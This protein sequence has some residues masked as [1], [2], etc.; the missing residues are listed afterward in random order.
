LHDIGKISVP[1]RILR[2]PGKLTEEEW[3]TMREHPDTG[4]RMLKTIR[5]PDAIATIVRQH[6]ERFD[7]TGY[8]HRLAGGA[9]SLGAR[10]FAVA[11]YYDAL[12]SNRPYRKA[13]PIERVL[14]DIRTASGSHFDPAVAETFLA[15][16]DGVFGDL[17]TR[18]EQELSDRRAA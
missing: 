9:I 5:I 8:P 16:P 17:R 2:K 12:T 6:H 14:D 3:V 18:I 10:I 13:Q 4:Y 15:I 1:D 11:D 7:G